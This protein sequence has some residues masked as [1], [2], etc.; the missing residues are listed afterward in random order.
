MSKISFIGFVL[1][2]FSFWSCN[3]WQPKQES[4]KNDKLSEKS[5]VTKKSHQVEEGESDSRPD[6]GFKKL[7]KSQKRN[8]RILKK[9]IGFVK[10]FS[11]K[12]N[13]SSRYDPDKKFSYNLTLYVGSNET[14]ITFEI[15]PGENDEFTYSCT[16]NKI[17]NSQNETIDFISKDPAEVIRQIKISLESI[18]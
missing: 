8:R 6:F 12:N 10:N 3:T 17:G 7:T 16:I 9:L 4:S 5:E 15:K 18:R 13:L 2:I 14:T 1:V 11:R